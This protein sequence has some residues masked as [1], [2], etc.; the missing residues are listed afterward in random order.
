MQPQDLA[1]N[2]ARQCAAAADAATP[3]AACAE[4]GC[5]GAVPHVVPSSWLPVRGMATSAA[6]AS[7]GALRRRSGLE[8]S[9]SSRGT[10]VPLHGRP[11]SSQASGCHSPEA[12]GG[13]PNDVDAT[14]SASSQASGPSLNNRP[15]SSHALGQETGGLPED[16][17]AVFSTATS[18]AGA[19]NTGPGPGGVAGSERGGLDEAPQ[20]SPPSVPSGITLAEA[21]VVR[22]AR[23]HK[24]QLPSYSELEAA[25]AAR[26]SSAKTAASAAGL[27]GDEARNVR[28]LSWA[29]CRVNQMMQQHCMGGRVRRGCSAGRRRRQVGLSDAALY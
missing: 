16:A 9:T 14:P 12:A 28:G 17:D 8:A 27:R 5:R 26:G 29:F 19:P 24:H 7:F 11:A 18:R 25:A 3:S 23:Q 4:P 10:G 21:P 13:L 2:C 6:A 15:P 1:Q 22:R 20:A